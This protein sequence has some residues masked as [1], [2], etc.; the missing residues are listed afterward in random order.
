MDGH[1]G[2]VCLSL[3]QSQFY[4]AA[5][6]GRGVP[7][8]FMRSHNAR[9]ALGVSPPDSQLRWTPKRA[10]G[11]SGGRVTVFLPIMSGGPGA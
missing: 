6:P 9:T 3:P 2:V 4:G 1:A 7:W 11:T 10:N 5:G 8:N